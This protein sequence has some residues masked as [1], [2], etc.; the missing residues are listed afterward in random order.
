MINAQHLM[1]SVV[2]KLNID[3]L[4][5][6]INRIQQN[7]DV[8]YVYLNDKCDWKAKHIPNNTDCVESTHGAG[9][10]I[11]KTNEGLSLYRLRLKVLCGKNDLVQNLMAMYMTK[12]N[13][14]YYFLYSKIY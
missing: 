5:I 6:Y 11:S 2:L 3:S 12:R 7:M 8:V 1:L 9:S 4:F 14:N 10:R 13:I